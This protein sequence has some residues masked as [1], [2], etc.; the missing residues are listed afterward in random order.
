MATP[1]GIG[2]NCSG[3]SLATVDSKGS[4]QIVPIDGEQTIPCAVAFPPDDPNLVLVGRDAQEALGHEPQSVVTDLVSQLGSNKSYLF[5][6]VYY[7]PQQILGLLLKGLLKRAETVIGNIELAVITVPANFSEASREATLQAGEIAGIKAPRLINKY[8]AAAL[9]FAA[10][11]NARSGTLLICDM[12]SNTSD[13]TIAKVLGKEVECITSQGDSR[14]GGTNFDWKLY[15]F[16]REIFHRENGFD[17]P[18]KPDQ[19]GKYY[20]LLDRAEAL[21]ITLS[22]H[23]VART[24]I[25][26]EDAGCCRVEISRTE[27]EESISH[28]LATFEMLIEAALEDAEITPVEIDHVLL[29]GADTNI[30]AVR[31]SIANTLSKEPSTFVRDDD[32]PTL[33]AAIYSKTIFPDFS[34]VKTD[35]VRL[36]EDR[37]S[38]ES[39]GS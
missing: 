25:I 10:S 34:H 12:N 24:L 30:P 17:L 35:Q 4:P 37:A 33:G 21:K 31:T 15:E 5:R 16:I 38:G 39:H 9:A 19:A 13:V 28:H 27:F 36:S 26:H 23:D 7:T 14:L 1:I 22:T 18:E 8:S 3:I 2:I 29:I 6:D 11:G 20:E 32:A